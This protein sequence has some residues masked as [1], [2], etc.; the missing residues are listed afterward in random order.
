ME[1]IRKLLT[2]DFGSMF[3]CH[4]GYIQ[5]GKKA[6]EEKLDYLENLSGEVKELHKQ[7]QSIEE[8]N[9]NLFPKKFPIISISEG[10]WDS[11]HIVSSIVAKL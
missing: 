10:E 8:I 3:C 9:E 4:A 1:S 11:L 6:L 5:N 7:G 2:Y